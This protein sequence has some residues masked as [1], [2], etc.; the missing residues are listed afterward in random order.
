M[1]FAL[2]ALKAIAPKDS[3]QSKGIS[4]KDFHVHGMIVDTVTKT[5]VVYF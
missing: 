4:V 1:A 3:L 5:C 2:K